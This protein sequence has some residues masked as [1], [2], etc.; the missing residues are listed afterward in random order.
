MLVSVYKIR[1]VETPL[2]KIFFS[3]VHKA[4]PQANLCVVMLHGMQRC[5]TPAEAKFK[6]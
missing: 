4:H 6:F 2:S 1:H 3:N 5:A